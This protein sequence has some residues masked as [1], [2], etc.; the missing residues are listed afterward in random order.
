VTHQ[1]YLDKAR[2]HLWQGFGRGNLFH[3]DPQ[4][5]IIVDRAEGSWIID[6][7]GD[8]Y[9]DVTGAQ[10]VV[11]VGYGNQRVIDAMVAQL[12]EMHLHPSTFPLQPRVIEL[13]EKI[14]S[15]FPD[16]FNKVFFTSNGTDAVE[17]AVR[18]VRQYFRMTGN[19]SRTNIVT[20]WRGYHGSSLAMTAASGNTRRRRLTNPLPDGFIQIEPP[21]CYRCPYQLHYP[22]C[23][24]RCADELQNVVTHHDPSNLAA[25]LGE[26]SI[27]AGGGIPAPAGYWRRIRDICDSAGM[28]LILDEV[29]TGFGRTGQWFE[30]LRLMEQ[31]GVYPDLITFGKGVSG[32]YYPISGVIVRD[33]IA[34]LFEKSSENSLQHGYTFGGTPVGAAAALATI[35]CLEEG[36]V[37]GV[38]ERSARLFA[39]L[40]KL[41]LSSTVIGDIRQNGLVM[42]LE[43]VPDNRTNGR[44]T[45]ET[46]VGRFI[47]TEGLSEG[48]LM[49]VNGGV[50][51]IFPP[52][53][54]TS[55]EIDELVDRLGKVVKAVEA[56]F[57]Q[58][59]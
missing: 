1:H 29:L 41:R 8:R 6:I 16:G 38:A 20:R 55:Q 58:V 11:S 36:I 5:A 26:P 12:K 17:T 22:E 13:A 30:C 54:I 52:L 9:L 46:L 59:S 33:E 57:G 51:N 4:T 44:F 43:L 31:E 14:S 35:A 2:E 47:L 49:V 10:A 7:D 25:F 50:I 53:T 39:G 24:I 15:F 28:L 27:G 32:G 48:L 21:Y 19:A 42:A 37:A 34:T 45:N 23:E 56:E 3:D 40:D 18:I